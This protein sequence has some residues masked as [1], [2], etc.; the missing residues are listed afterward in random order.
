[1]FLSRL[2][3]SYQFICISLVSVLLLATV[4][5]FSRI[6]QQSYHEKHGGRVSRMIE[7]K[8]CGAAEFLKKVL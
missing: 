6:S 1:M 5:T 8:A 3:V 4:H 7:R 2:S